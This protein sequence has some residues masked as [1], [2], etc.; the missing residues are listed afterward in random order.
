MVRRAVLGLSPGSHLWESSGGSDFGV[1]VAFWGV[2]DLFLSPGLRQRRGAPDKGGAPTRAPPD[3]LGWFG[4]LVPPSLRQ[5]QGSFQRGVQRVVQSFGVPCVDT[6]PG[7][8]CC[9]CAQ[10]GQCVIYGMKL[11]GT[12]N[13]G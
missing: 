8:N 9:E 13:Y 7:D 2:S 5:A 11:M 6:S 3:P 1:W 4:V 12:H 10:F